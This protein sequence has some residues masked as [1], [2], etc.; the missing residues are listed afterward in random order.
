MISLIYLYR[1]GVSLLLGALVGLEREK[2][3]KPAGL[4][5]VMLVCLGATL[6][7]II[8][9]D[10][11]KTY[12]A[13]GEGLRIIAYTIASMGFLGSG[14][15]IQ[16]KGN[17]EGITTASILWVIVAV[18]ILC[19]EGNF[20]LAIIATIAIYGILKLKYLTKENGDTNGTKSNR[21]C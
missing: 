18:G 13:I 21:V 12:N 1:I 17:V 4:R 2:Q 14:V 5:T 8:A 15:V 9:L 11:G 10:F 16:H 3:D 19:G 7:T 6:F 20:T